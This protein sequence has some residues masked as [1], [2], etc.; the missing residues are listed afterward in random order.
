MLSFAEQH[1]SS[2]L[3]SFLRHT[4]RLSEGKVCF[5]GQRRSTSANSDADS[6]LMKL[7]PSIAVLSCNP[8]SPRLRPVCCRCRATAKCRL[9]HSSQ[10]PLLPYAF[11][12]WPLL[13][14]RWKAHGRRTTRVSLFG[15]A[16]VIR[17][18]GLRVGPRPKLPV[19]TTTGPGRYWRSKAAQSEELSLP[20][21][22]TAYLASGSGAPNRK[23]L[24]HYSRVVDTALEAGIRPF[25]TLF[26]RP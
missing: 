2:Q 23:G 13:P 3:C 1:K 8:Q 14:S 22:L 26:P 11:G 20:H 15:T 12:V 5:V 6:T 21:L 19:T 16:S 10:V 25:C 9:L 18:G 24:D 17:A 7:P 4:P